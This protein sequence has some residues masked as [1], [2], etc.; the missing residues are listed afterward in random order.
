[1][2]AEAKKYSMVQECTDSYRVTELD[3]GRTRVELVV[4]PR[5]RALWLTK[6]SE[7][8]TDDAEVAALERE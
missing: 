2:P 4:P 6:L 5:F 3:D 8:R 1:M 7:L